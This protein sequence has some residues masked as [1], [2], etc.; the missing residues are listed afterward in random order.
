[1]LPGRLYLTRQYGTVAFVDYRKEGVSDWQ[2]SQQEI[3]KNWIGIANLQSGT[4][5]EVRLSVT[6]GVNTASSDIDIIKTKGIPAAFSLGANLNWFG[7][8]VISVL[9]I[10]ALAALIYRLYKRRPE[11]TKERTYTAPPRRRDDYEDDRSDRDYHGDDR[12]YRDDDEYSRGSY[13]DEEWKADDDFLRRRDDERYDDYDKRYDSDYKREQDDDY[14]IDYRY[15]DDGRRYSTDRSDNNR[16]RNGER[17]FQPNSR[18]PYRTPSYD[19]RSSSSND[20]DVDL[21]E[22]TKFGDDGYPV[23]TE[24]SETPGASSLV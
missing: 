3:S 15:K 18:R 19:N 14:N 24:T 6:N 20:E 1:M 11:P 10:I 12:G 22:P 17:D 9:I 23:D 2:Q 16:Y 8:L 13:D 4:S 21:Q 7:G 5:Y